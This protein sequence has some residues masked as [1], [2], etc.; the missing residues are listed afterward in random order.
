MSAAISPSERPPRLE[1]AR[2]R[3]RV[4]VER[5]RG[6][7]VLAGLYQEGCLKVR[8]PRAEAVDSLSLVLMNNS[9]GV[10][11]GD[12]L[13][14][15]ITLGPGAA[16]TV[17]SAGAERFYR[18]RAGEACAVV[19]NRLVLA[20][21]AALEWLP[22]ES[23]LFDGAALDRTLSVEMAEG[24]RL[25]A[26]ESLLFGRAAMGETLRAQH[27]V[28]RLHI[29]RA[30][31]LVCHDAVRLEG[32]ASAHLARPAI[33]GGAGAAAALVL[34]APDTDALLEPLRAALAQAPCEAGASAR[35]G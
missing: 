31:R 22:Q 1:R 5:R 9:G 17:V 11:P 19:R 3:L 2:G 30:G 23:I 24:A 25:L 27:L 4:G 35:D 8:F 29:R 13:A 15:G 34:A 28:D 26:V 7:S 12:D 10:A 21:G 33:A 32:A 14:T 18:G 6:A 16:A 20:A